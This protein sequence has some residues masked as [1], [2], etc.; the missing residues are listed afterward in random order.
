M[1]ASLLAVVKS[2]YY[3]IFH[4]RGT[5]FIYLCILFYILQLVKCLPFY[6]PE[7]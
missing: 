2:M 6:I 4:E 1:G 7:A 5:P 3:I